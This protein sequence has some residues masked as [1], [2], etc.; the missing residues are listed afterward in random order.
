MILYLIELG[1]DVNACSIHNVTYL[2]YLIKIAVSFDTGRFHSN[3]ELSEK[4]MGRNMRLETGQVDI[5]GMLEKVYGKSD[6]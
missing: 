4:M 2:E 5:T 1:A 6:S 3:K